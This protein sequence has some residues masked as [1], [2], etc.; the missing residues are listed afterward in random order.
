MKVSFFSKDYTTAL[1]GLCALVVILVHIPETYSNPIQDGIGSFA[2]VAVSV[3]F[4]ISSFGLHRQA[5]LKPAYLSHFWRNRLSALLIPVI[6]INICRLLTI[7]LTE[8]QWHFE[9]LL[10]TDPYVLVLLCY[11]VLFY[12]ILRF[13][14]PIANKTWGYT[15]EITAVIISS[16]SL[17]FFSPNRANSAEMGW[18]Y[19]QWGIVWGILL[20]HCFDRFVAW[21]NSGHRLKLLC[22]FLIGLAAG[23]AYLK[24]KDIFFGG[25][26][27]LKVILGFSLILLLFLLTGHGISSHTVN[28]FLGN[29]SYEIYL[30]HG[31]IMSM[32]KHNKPDLGSWTFIGMTVVLTLVFSYLI[33][34]LGKPV[35]KS[36]RTL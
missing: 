27:V 7:G 6:I 18:C 11:Y 23:L 19:E 35:V 17:Y 29:I 32:L 1:K 26:Y 15:I 16:L 28:R 4:L 21:M 33:Y 3:F 13:L 22:T 8:G 20:F 30:S 25:Q 14:T 2:F 9:Y 10:K 5:S 34:I 31:F 24:C 36:C 12:I